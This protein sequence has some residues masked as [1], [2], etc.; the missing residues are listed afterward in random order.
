MFCSLRVATQNFNQKSSIAYNAYNDKRGYLAHP[1]PSIIIII[2]HKLNVI[3]IH[4]YIHMVA[5]NV[6]LHNESSVKY[7]TV[8]SV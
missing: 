7:K 3:C 1:P 6:M 4:I 5:L 8:M 2:I